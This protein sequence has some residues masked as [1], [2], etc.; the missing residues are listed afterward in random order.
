MFLYLS[1]AMFISKERRNVPPAKTQ[2]NRSTRR[3]R[4]RVFI[5]KGKRSIV[6]D[7]IE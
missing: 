4:K 2:S 7:T 5:A 6:A 1:R 3:N